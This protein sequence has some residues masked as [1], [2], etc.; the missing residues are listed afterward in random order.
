MQASCSYVRKVKG[1][2]HSSPVKRG[3]TNSGHIKLVLLA[4][5]V[6]QWAILGGSSYNYHAVFQLPVELNVCIESRMSQ[7]FNKIP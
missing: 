3:S 2:Q 1:F 7:V 4:Y 6:L 5:W